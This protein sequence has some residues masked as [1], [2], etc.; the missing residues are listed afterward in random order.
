MV[1]WFFVVSLLFQALIS[2]I[3]PLTVPCLCKRKDNVCWSPLHQRGVQAQGIGT[4]PRKH[5]RGIAVPPTT[6]VALAPSSLGFHLKTFPPHQCLQK[7][8]QM[9]ARRIIR[10]TLHGCTVLAARHPTA[11][12]KC[13][14]QSDTQGRI[15]V[16]IIPFATRWNHQ[17]RTATSEH[18]NEKPG[19]T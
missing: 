19:T 1:L 7:P 8:P 15:L 3:Y 9:R 18:W 11:A 13:T 5:L 2:F 14:Y 17:H 10:N 16:L 4:H 12:G 6:H